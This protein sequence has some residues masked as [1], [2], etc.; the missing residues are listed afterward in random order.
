MLHSLA[1]YF[2]RQGK[3][4][5]RAQVRRPL[6]CGVHAAPKS[7]GIFPLHLAEQECCISIRTLYIDMN[8]LHFPFAVVSAIILLRPNDHADRLL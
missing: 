5:P 7:Y 1:W 4:E 3:T 6:M 2:I 8:D